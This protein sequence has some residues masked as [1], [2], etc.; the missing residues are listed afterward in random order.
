[1]PDEGKNSG[2]SLVL[3]WENDDVTW[4]RSIRT[5]LKPD[6]NMFIFFSCG[7]LD[8]KWVCLCNF[9]IHDWIGF[10]RRLQ[11]IRK[12]EKIMSERVSIH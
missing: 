12:K 6:N 4:K 10:P 2:G 9:V 8:Y 1:M 3:I 5:D 7:K 11:T